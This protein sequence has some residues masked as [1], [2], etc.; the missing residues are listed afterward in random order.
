MGR[1]AVMEGSDG[2]SAPTLGTEES[3]RYGLDGRRVG[4]DSRGIVIENGRKVLK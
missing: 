1:V 3:V 2:I 4:E